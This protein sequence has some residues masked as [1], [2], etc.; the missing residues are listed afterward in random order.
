M[1]WWM[2]CLVDTTVPTPV[3]RPRVSIVYRPFTPAPMKTV[4]FTRSSYYSG[5]IIVGLRRL[6]ILWS[7]VSRGCR[8]DTIPSVMNFGVIWCIA[9]LLSTFDVYVYINLWCLCLYSCLFS[10]IVC[11]M[12][13]SIF[14]IELLYVYMCVC[15][16][17][18]LVKDYCVTYTFTLNIHRDSI[19][20]PE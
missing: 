8:S 1:L 14:V 18:A 10:Q 2:Y 16:S 6:S 7:H 12:A 5:W 11:Q 20:K 19:P 17:F 13:I 9:I 15:R 4:T 3:Y